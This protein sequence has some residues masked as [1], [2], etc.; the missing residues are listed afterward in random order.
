MWRISQSP[1]IGAVRHHL[2]DNSRQLNYRYLLDTLVSWPTSGQVILVGLH[3]T[4]TPPPLSN[5]K[6]AIRSAARK[7]GCASPRRDAMRPPGMATHYEE[8]SAGHVIRRVMAAWCVRAV[9]CPGGPWCNDT[10]RSSNAP[11]CATLRRT[12]PRSAQPGGGSACLAP[13]SQQAASR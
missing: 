12:T 7:P 13:S 9:S 6:L 5:R 8:T 1:Y 2:S 3:L 10:P 11:R 4:P